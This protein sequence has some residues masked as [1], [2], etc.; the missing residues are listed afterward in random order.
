MDKDELK[1]A[2]EKALLFKLRLFG[3]I[4]FVGELYNRKILLEKT[5]VSVFE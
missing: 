3:N 2:Q 5:L 4:E 1:A